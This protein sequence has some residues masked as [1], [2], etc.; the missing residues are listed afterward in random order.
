MAPISASKIL[1]TK[2]FSQLLLLSTCSILMHYNSSEATFQPP[3]TTEMVLYFQ[4]YGAGPNA[5]FSTVAGIA[6]KLW[7]F[8]QFGTVYV[9]DDPITETPDPTS[10]M[11]GRA[12]GMYVISALDGSTSH[13]MFS[14]VFTNRAYNGSTLQIQ[15]TGQQLE[16]GSEYSVVAGTGKFRFARGYVKFETIYVDAPRAYSVIRCNVTVRLD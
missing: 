14:I 4:D 11:V 7:T 15:G 1:T 5:T 13:A 12:Q 8:T 9:T 6:G 3:Q 2:M 10:A 16:V